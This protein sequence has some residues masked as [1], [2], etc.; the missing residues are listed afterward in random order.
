LF[1]LFFFF[2]LSNRKK[3][4]QT[5]KIQGVKKTN[6]MTDHSRSRTKSFSST[7]MTHPSQ[8]RPTQGIS[9]VRTKD[10]YKY[11]QRARS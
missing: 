3:K 2:V 6:M 11:K 5:D 9:L 8:A 10:P 1:R 4:I 7:L